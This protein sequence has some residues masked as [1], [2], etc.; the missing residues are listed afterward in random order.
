MHNNS[1][2][3]APA[4]DNSLPTHAVTAV[5]QVLAWSIKACYCIR[6]RSLPSSATL[7]L[8]Y[9]SNFAL[10]LQIRAAVQQ[11]PRPA[12]RSPRQPPSRGADQRLRFRGAAAKPRSA[13]MFPTVAQPAAHPRAGPPSP[14][15]SP[16]SSC[17]HP[18]VHWMD[19]RRLVDEDLL[20]LTCK[21]D[22]ESCPLLSAS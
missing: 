2:L 4:S 6:L 17:S 14:P 12:A 15:A 11:Q 19:R 7:L 8:K 16:G 18:T 10:S 1:L 5:M 13:V 20:W 22:V 9:L 21:S 3:H